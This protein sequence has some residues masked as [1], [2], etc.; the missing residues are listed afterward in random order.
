MTRLQDRQFA[1]TGA[2]RVELL[3]E[4]FDN[5]YL[6]SYPFLVV[7]PDGR[8][9]VTPLSFSTEANALHCIARIERDE[10]EAQRRD[11]APPDLAR[12]AEDARSYLTLNG[13]LPREALVEV[14][15]DGSRETLTVMVVRPASGAQRFDR[16]LWTLTVCTGYENPEGGLG[17][18]A[19]MRFAPVVRFDGLL[20]PI[21]VGL[22]TALADRLPPL[23]ESEV[24]RPFFRLNDTDV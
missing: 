14:F 9:G 4:P 18:L 19:G 6:R 15:L 8:S 1:A 17:P 10:A 16:T 3:T 11:N 24:V 20:T 23:R 21:A 7:G 13:L 5:D 22:V 12:L 2:H